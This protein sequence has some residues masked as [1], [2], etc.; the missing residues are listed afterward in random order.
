[1]VTF[2]ASIFEFNVGLLTEGVH[3]NRL[4][5]N[6]NVNGQLVYGGQVA[7]FV[8]LVSNFSLYSFGA[9]I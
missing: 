2:T 7:W 6:P 5:T 4:P 8:L 9:I 3:G 1:M